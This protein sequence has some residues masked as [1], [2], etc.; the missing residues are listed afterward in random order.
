MNKCTYYVKGMHCAACE[1]LIE[2]KLVS[3][4]DAKKA[5]ASLKDNKVDIY[6]DSSAPKTSEL[7][8]LFSSD[9]YTFSTNVTDK[10]INKMYTF[11]ILILILVT[12]VFFEKNGLLSGVNVSSTSSLGAFFLF[13]FAASI[14]TCAALVGGIIISM[15]KKWNEMYAGASESVR[16]KPFILFNIGRVIAFGI[17]GG[18]L[19]TIGNI[20]SISTTLSSVFV[21][22]ISVL[23]I[24]L[25]LQMVGL[26]YFSI[27][28]PK[29][30]TS[31][32]IDEKRFSGN[33]M[34]LFLG[35][36]TFF[37]PCGFTLVAQTIALT[38]GSFLQGSLIMLAFVLGTLPM[39]SLISFTSIKVN[40]LPAV[41]Q[42]FNF[43]AG[44][45]VVLFALYNINA[46]L[47]V[48][49]IPSLTDLTAK[50]VKV[51]PEIKN[52][53]PTS[54]QLI[55]LEAK[56]FAYYPKDISV[57]ANRPVRLEI[58]NTGAVGCANA[59]V[60]RGLFNGVITL[61]DGI[62]VV[63]FTPTTKGIYKITC[64]MGMVPPV[65]VRVL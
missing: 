54:T 47:N 45:L 40:S 16:A 10:P 41:I 62:N 64:T 12:F 30:L 19:G 51:T 23:M 50:N 21:I 39:L 37:V 4:G 48:L 52:S 3:N 20:F 7:N 59:V 26:N 11:G 29:T 22:V 5:R 58:M 65:S 44:V 2:K 36:G 33:L 60:G 17:L 43:V 31:K 56:G 6:Y 61:K 8:K 25:G 13:G 46:Q 49:G 28:F 38:S 18:L 15:S 1:V 14:S 55:Q 42:K 35:A 32:F 9:G 57:Y 24:F 53:D 34:P 27:K 63:E